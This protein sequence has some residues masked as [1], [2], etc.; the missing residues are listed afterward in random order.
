VG[1]ED[2]FAPLVCDARAES[3]DVATRVKRLGPVTAM[4]V[5][6]VVVVVVVVAPGE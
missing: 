6:V 3:G 4:F 5:V 2:E 1:A